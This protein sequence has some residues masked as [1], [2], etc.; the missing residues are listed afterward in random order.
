MIRTLPYADLLVHDDE[1]LVL[2]GEPESAPKREEQGGTIVRLS[3][4]GAAVLQRAE[5]GV[6]FEALANALEDEFGAPPTGSTT[7]ALQAVLQ[8]L[9]AQRLVH[10]D[11]QEQEHHHDHEGGE[12]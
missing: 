9:H 4:I 11:E 5:E 1:A 10:L 8:A 6:S 2:L 12:A 3:A 7:E